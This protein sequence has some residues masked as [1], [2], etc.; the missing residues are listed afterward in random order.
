MDFLWKRGDT[1]SG[2]LMPDR[3]F[4][5]FY[6]IDPQYLLSLGIKALVIDIDNTL[7]P[8][9]QAIPNERAIAWFASLSENGISAAL[10]SNNKR[11]RVET[12]N[13][14]LGL[15]AYCKSGK[16]S[17]KNIRRAMAQMGSDKTNTAVLGDQLLTDVLGGKHIGL[18]AFLVPP[19][20]DRSSAFFRFKRSLE[21][22]TVKR[23]VKHCS[24]VESVSAC[25]FWLDK[26]YKSNKE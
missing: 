4:E 13:E 19:I 23:Y 21:V 5:H 8:Y 17:A 12:F 22:P 3:V 24:D 15:P 26:R 11:E 9:E 20:K 1:V 6:D 18:R 14:S 10:I 2:L 16:P 7:A 25:G